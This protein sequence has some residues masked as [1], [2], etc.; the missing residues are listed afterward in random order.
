MNGRQESDDSSTGSSAGGGMRAS[1]L[2]FQGC[3]DLAR[4]GFPG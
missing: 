2:G 1:Y 3:F 4:S